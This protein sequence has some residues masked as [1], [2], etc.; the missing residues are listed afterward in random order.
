MFVGPLAL[1]VCGNI[2]RTMERVA[3]RFSVPLA[4]EKTE[5]S[6]TVVKFLRIV[7]Y[8]ERMEWRLPEDNRGQLKAVL[9]GALGKRKLVLYELQSLFGRLNFACRIIPMGRVF[10]RRL[11]MAT[12]G[13]C[14]QLYYV[15]LSGDLRADLQVWDGFLV[16]YNGQSLFFRP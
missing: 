9:R 13:V 7:I 8:S 14:S 1:R 3:L 6:A 4:P 10:C 11:S 12:A 2:L 16:R 5:G 15:R